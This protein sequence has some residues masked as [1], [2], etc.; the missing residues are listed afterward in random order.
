MT[1]QLQTAHVSV[2]TS[3]L[4]I[5]VTVRSVPRTQHMIFISTNSC[6]FLVLLSQSRLMTDR[7]PVKMIYFVPVKKL[8]VSPGLIKNIPLLYLMSCCVCKN[9]IN[10]FEKKRKCPCAVVWNGPD[11]SFKSHGLVSTKEEASGGSL[12]TPGC[13]STLIAEDARHPVKNMFL[14]AQTGLEV[15]QLLSTCGGSPSRLAGRFDTCK[16]RNETLRSELWSLVCQPVWTSRTFTD[17]MQGASCTSGAIWGSVSCSRTLRHAAQ[18]ARSWDLI[19][20]PSD[21]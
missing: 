2:R 5:T 18:L 8:E 7:L 15:I 14:S 21:H 10:R 3:A 1:N 6:R 9:S 13:V 17:A 12:K 11:D 19:Q 4:I 20:Q 16:H